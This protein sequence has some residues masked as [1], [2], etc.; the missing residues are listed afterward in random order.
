MTVEGVERLL[1]TGADVITGG[2]HAFEGAE[3][4][5]VL[6]HD[7]RLHRQSTALVGRVRSDAPRR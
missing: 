4:E 6:S 7:G 1:D 5:A 3:V 2:N